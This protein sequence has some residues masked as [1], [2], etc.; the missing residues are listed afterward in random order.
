M[1]R[2]Y[3]NGRVARDDSPPLKTPGDKRFSRSIPFALRSPHDAPDSRSPSSGSSLANAGP[4]RVSP[5]PLSRL[6]DL[7]PLALGSASED[8]KTIVLSVLA[9]LLRRSAGHDLYLVEAKPNGPCSRG[10]DRDSDR[11]RFRF[12]VGRRHALRHDSIPQA[13]RSFPFT[14]ISARA[15]SPA[16]RRRGSDLHPSDAGSRGRASGVGQLR[17]RILGDARLPR[18]PPTPRAPAGP[19]G[20]PCDTLR[21]LFSQPPH[22]RQPPLGRQLSARPANA[23]TRRN[24]WRP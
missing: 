15:S 3:S 20:S 22:G 24:V 12:A 18:R 4:W 16:S 8:R 14:G 5:A 2:R 21:N 7:A 13:V 11:W 6:V 9:D 17:L 10:G 1:T 23:A 19:R